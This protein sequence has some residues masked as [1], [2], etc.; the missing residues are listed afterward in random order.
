[1]EACRGSLCDEV[2][3]IRDAEIAFVGSWARERFLPWLILR[4]IRWFPVGSPSLGYTELL[5]LSDR[6]DWPRGN[7]SFSVMFGIIRQVKSA[8]SVVQWE[9]RLFW[10]Y[11]V[12]GGSSLIDIAEC[13]VETEWRRVVG[14]QSKWGHLSSFQREK[15]FCEVVAATSSIDL[16]IELIYCQS[17]IDLGSQ[18]ISSAA[19]ELSTKPKSNIV[20]QLTYCFLRGGF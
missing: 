15:R 16:L 5:Y 4:F 20:S 18:T 13:P 10:R 7:G 6:V 17:L 12:G 19:G 8:I 14:K 2:R 1:M 3:F 9:L 11:C